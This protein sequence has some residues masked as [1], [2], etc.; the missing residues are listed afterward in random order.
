MSADALFPD[1]P[2]VTDALIIGAGPAG[3]FL[4]FEL[5]LLGI[6]AQI[7]DAL[8]RPGGQCVELYGDKL[9]Y[10]IPAVPACTGQELAERLMEQVRPF[11]PGLHLSQ[12]VATLEARADGFAVGTSR[13]VQFRA[14]TVFLAAGVGAFTPR[15]LQADGIEAFEGTQVFHRL[16]ASDDLGGRQV[17]VVGGDDAALDRVAALLAQPPA[18]RPRAVT[19]LHRRAVLQATADRQARFA[20][21]QAAGDATFVVGQVARLHAPDGRLQEVVVAAPDG[22]TPSLPVDAV[23]V[24]LGL[25]PRLG[26]LAEW[27]LVLERK[28]VPVDTGTFAT[29]VPGLYA[30]GDAIT[31]PGKKRLILSAFHEA[32]LAAFA[33]SERLFPERSTVLQYT[34]SSTELHRRLGVAPPADRPATAK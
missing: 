15:R 18:R 33:A 12:E 30:V 3:L 27:G 4:A 29:Q 28:Q 8:D 6:H 21:Q 1:E 20:A 9:L 5:G 7:V 2:I 17:L 16:H 23:V 25:S 24:A 31:Y 10:D 14:R 32:T 34:T 26:P 19:L 22:S 13:G 11:A